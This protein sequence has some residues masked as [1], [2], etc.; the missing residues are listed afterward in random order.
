MAFAIILSETTQRPGN[1]SL[2]WTAEVR[3]V[4]GYDHCFG[5]GDKE[6]HAG[7]DL[8]CPTFT[9]KRHE[10][11]SEAIEE[12]LNHVMKGPGSIDG[13]HVADDYDEN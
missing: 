4:A 7:P 6:N 8:E 13:D 5:C 3:E 10:A 11:I 1:K 12:A 9:S 2:G